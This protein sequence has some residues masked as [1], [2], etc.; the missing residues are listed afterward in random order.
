MIRALLLFSL[1]VFA[2]LPLNTLAQSSNDHFRVISFN[3]RFDNPDDGPDAWPNRKD[4]VASVVRLHEADI[5]GTQEGLLHQLEDMDERLPGFAWIG[6]GRDA[7]GDE[8]E[9]SAIF[10]RTTRFEVLKESTFWLSEEPEEPGSVGWDAALP[11]IVTWAEMEDRESGR[12]FFVF[13]TH[14]DHQGE[15]AR[16]ESARLIREKIREVAGE[17]PVVLMGDLNTTEQDPPYQVLAE[18]DELMLRDGFYVSEHPHHGPTSTWNGFERIHPER[19]I[20]YVFVGESFAVHQHAILTDVWDEGRFPS[21]HLP[22]LAEI[23]FAG[24]SD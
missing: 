15:E 5:V 13:N 16:L 2:G 14:F 6:V 10:Y 23:G 11:R 7:G 12:R 18:E 1:L 22:V 3:I 20:D 9:F 4:N 21:D 19:R 24:D 8:G 17:A